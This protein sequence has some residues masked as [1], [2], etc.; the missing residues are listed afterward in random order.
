MWLYVFVSNTYYILLYNIADFIEDHIERD[1]ED[2]TYD[3]LK[4][5]SSFQIMETEYIEL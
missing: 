3:Y 1:E 5:L 4:Y 2:L